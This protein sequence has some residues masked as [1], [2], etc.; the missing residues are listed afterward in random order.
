M[1]RTNPIQA[2]FW[3]Q[4]VSSPFYDDYF[5]RI[6]D[7]TVKGQLFL[8]MIFA[9]QYMLP[10]NGKYTYCPGPVTGGLRAYEIAV[11]LG[12]TAVA[13]LNQKQYSKNKLE[14]VI[15]PN[16]WEGYARSQAL[17]AAMPKGD[18]T[19]FI[20]PNFVEDLV[21]QFVESGQQIWPEP[22][23]MAFWM[24]TMRE[25]MDALAICRK[26]HYNWAYSN[27]SI[28]EVT[29]ATCIEA[30]LRPSR[31]AGDMVIFDAD[32][33]LDAKRFSVL[34]LYD[35]LTD[36]AAAA[37]DILTMNMKI[38]AQAKGMARLFQI[39][40]LIRREQIVVPTCHS[41]N[42]FTGDRNVS[43]ALDISS[44]D[45]DLRYLRNQWMPY[46]FAHYGDVKGLHL[47]V[48]KDAQDRN[49][50]QQRL[51][52]ETITSGRVHRNFKRR[53]RYPINPPKNG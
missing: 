46:I 52:S 19:A 8:A 36:I 17:K 5:A 2:D 9:T 29:E 32:G 30:G 37:D 3:T 1:F 27:G 31:P 24:E 34:S 23:F 22:A 11:R 47:V 39:Y 28:A 20:A 43:T 40:Q 44:K 7:E 38:P 53:K 16:F 51:D 18:K 45:D 10:G 25:K 12:L 15:R 21:R 50:Q 14:D 35:R 42:P 13:D 6:T 33:A 48:N 4:D 26:G 41:V 49:L